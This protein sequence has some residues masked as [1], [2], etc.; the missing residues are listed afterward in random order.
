MG[1]QKIE[2]ILYDAQ[3]GRLS[4]DDRT[5]EI[6]EG[7]KDRNNKISKFRKDRLECHT[8]GKIKATQA[9]HVDPVR[10]KSIANEGTIRAR[11][12]DVKT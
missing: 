2:D 10:L 12:S 4:A 9:P 1:I 3:S 7:V 5:I 11:A 6:G 8:A